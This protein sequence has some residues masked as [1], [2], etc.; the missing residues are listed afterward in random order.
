MKIAVV[1]QSERASK[2]LRPLLDPKNGPPETVFFSGGIAQAEKAVNQ[3]QPDILIL[4][5]TCDSQTELAGLERITLRHPGMAVI[6]LCPAQSPEFLIEVMRI[7]VREVLSPPVTKQALQAAVDR[8]QHRAVLMRPPARKGKVLAFI[9][10]KGG[11]G[12]TFLA[13]NLGYA[14]AAAH[15][16]KVALFDLNLQFGDAS[17]FVSDRTPD[18][19]IADVAKNI[20]RLD[21]SFLASSMVQVLPDF[22][23]LAAP[24]S[25]E[26]AAEVRPDHIEALISLAAAHYDFVILDMG[27]TLDAVSVKALDH[28]DVIFPVLQETLP[29]IRDAKRLLATFQSLGY[30][31]D[32]IHLIVNRY[33]KG[34]DIRLEDVEHTLGMKVFRTVPNS[35]DAVSASVNQGVPVM[36]I[37]GHDPVTKTL[38]RWGHDLAAGPVPKK[39][40]WLAHLFH[41]A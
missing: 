39:G 19:T 15:G 10:C 37:A 41:H 25:P 5:A 12:A 6:L 23:V 16:R 21:A 14:L 18:N 13:A 17:L 11:S 7:G 35:F 22:G 33:E 27:R 36:K 40:G 29:F 4:D 20:Q 31:K 24:E 8:V 38:V 28:A 34:G 26:R 2:D 3:S 32:K 9:A 1:S 30:G